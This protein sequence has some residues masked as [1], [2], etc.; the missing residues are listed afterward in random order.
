MDAARGRAQ[1][2]TP[3][4]NHGPRKVVRGL[5]AQGPRIVEIGVR[6]QGVQK[7]SDLESLVLLDSKEALI[8]RALADAGEAPS[9]NGTQGC[10][11]HGKGHWGVADT[12]LKEGADPNQTDGGHRS[13]LMIAALEGH[14]GLCELLLSRGALLE[15]A[16]R[17]GLTSLGWACLK[18]QLQTATLLIKQGC[19][20]EHA[21]KSGR[22][23]LDL[24]AYKGNPDVVTLLLENGANM[25]HIDLNGMRPLDRAISCRNPGA[26]QC[27]LRRGAKLGPATWAMAKG[28]PDI[29]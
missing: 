26:V 4:D 18:G 2:E 28:K 3:Q 25:E 9:R 6:V 19:D 10:S 7:G 12:L 16:D 29:M 5:F 22:S 27:F 17:D 24:A 23:C 8:F 13:P 15:A 11:I 20:L 21:D 14:L 1:D